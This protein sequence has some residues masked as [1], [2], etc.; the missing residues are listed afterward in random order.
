MVKGSTPTFKLKLPVHSDSITYIQ[1]VFVQ[2]N[3]CVL[4]VEEDRITYDGYYASFILEEWETLS[5]A[6]GVV[7]EIQL[8]VSTADGQVF[9][10]DIKKLAIMKKYP[11]DLF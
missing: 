2:G 3:E 8:T 10:S 7:A 11:E 1:V 5:F 9:V 6:P 4:T